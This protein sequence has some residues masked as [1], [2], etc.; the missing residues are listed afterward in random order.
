MIRRLAPLA[1]CLDLCLALAPP[2]VA[3]RPLV[4]LDPLREADV[5]ILGEVHDNP[6][7]HLWQAEVLTALAPAAVVFEMLTPDQAGQITPD[8]LA[9]PAALADAI[10]WEASGWPD[11]TLY[12]P[13]FEAL[14]GAAV[15][16]AAL[17][18]EDVRAAVSEG[19]AARFE[20]DASQ[21]GLDVPLP[22]DT[23]ATREGLQAEAHCNALPPALLPGMVEA[24]RLRDAGFAASVLE[25]FGQT[26]GPV[27][28]ITGN[29]HA[30][31]DWA[32]P[33]M[34]ALAAPE[35]SVVS[36]GQFE[37]EPGPDAPFDLWRVT[38]PAERG[39]PCAGFQ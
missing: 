29:G 10:G 31:S 28:L 7:H 17:P 3:A 5:V 25:A 14:G 20:G 16:G 8:L 33:A 32:V 21:Y 36:V 9:T 13:V 15:F 12:Q 27:V 1:L 18:Y 4:T 38:D 35:V 19:A 34:I 23:Q 26:G 30:R 6:A 2:P 24:Q 37:A 11:F 39:D 22:E